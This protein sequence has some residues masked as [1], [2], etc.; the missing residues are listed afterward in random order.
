MLDRVKKTIILPLWRRCYAV[1]HRKEMALPAGRRAFVFL[2][3]D[4]GNIGDLAIAEAQRQFLART[5]PA[6]NVVP[7]P[8]SMTAETLHSIRRQI[9][10]GDVVTLIGGGNMGSLYPDIEELRQQVIGAF[11]GN[12]VVCFPQ[13][14]DWTDSGASGRALARMVRVYS[15][16]PD[17][18]LFARE[19]VSFKKLRELFADRPSVQVGLAPDIVLSAGAGTL[20]AAGG[21]QPDGVLLCLRND[22]ERRLGADDE[23][24]LRQALAETGLELEE[25][26]THAGGAGL[27]PERCTQLVAGKL[28]QFQ[29]ARLVVTDRLHGMI[30]AVLAGTPCLVLPNSNHKIRQTWLDWL[31]QVP[32]VRFLALSEMAD[33]GTAVRRLLDTPRRDPTA[34]VVDTEHFADLRAA[35]EVQ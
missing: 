19:T 13:T 28:G 20:A 22:G 33:A 17:L 35:L 29:A 7:V 30:L 32:Q 9:A 24:V 12:R 4:Y 26:D 21:A 27:A 31:V 6:F 25:T 1:L 3:A 5:L 23:A 2:S 10:P 34:P 15:R 16:H 18:Y 8:I 14:L 11:H